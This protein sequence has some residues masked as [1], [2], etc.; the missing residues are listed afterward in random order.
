MNSFM[1]NVRFCEMYFKIN[2]S[3]YRILVY[4]PDIK[5]EIQSIESTT[6]IIFLSI[7]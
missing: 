7:K 1:A 4:G 5:A 2:D 6:N 3:V